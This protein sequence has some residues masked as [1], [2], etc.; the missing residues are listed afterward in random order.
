[1]FSLYE[2]SINRMEQNEAIKLL[3]E[4]EKII[5]INI[6]IIKNSNDYYN[7]DDNAKYISQLRN[8]R[9][10]IMNSYIKILKKA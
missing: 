5:R 6:K 4:L 10:K 3:S 1:M 8:K 7:Q 2:A 9:N